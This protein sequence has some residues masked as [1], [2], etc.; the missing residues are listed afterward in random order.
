MRRYSLLF[1]PLLCACLF[2]VLPFAEAAMSDELFFEIC[3]KGSPSE[4]EA[5]LKAGANVN[6]NR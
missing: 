5:A 2:S 6:G 4:I 3:E 1:V